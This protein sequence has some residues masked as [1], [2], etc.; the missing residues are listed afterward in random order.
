MPNSGSGKGLVWIKEGITDKQTDWCRRVIREQDGVIAEP[1]LEKVQDFAM[2]FFVENGNVNFSGYSLFKSAVSGAYL[3][4]FLLSDTDT[5]K[6]LSKRVS[7]ETLH[8]LKAFYLKKL[9]EYFPHYNGYIGVDMMVCGTEKDYRIQPCV[10]MNL[11]MNMGVAARIFHDKFVHPDSSGKFVVDFFKRE[12]D[13]VH[14]QQKMRKDFPLSVENGK[15][16]SGFMNLTP[17]SEETNYV[18]WVVVGK[19]VI[20]FD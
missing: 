13:A 14:F 1:V 20:Q 3:G 10:E 7:I 17:I 19:N 16:M 15:I 5:E 18:A 11:R 8:W 9:P 2:E 4:N 6:T 12:G